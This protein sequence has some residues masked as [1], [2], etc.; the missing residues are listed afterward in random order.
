MVKS[1]ASTATACALAV[2][3]CSSTHDN[4]LPKLDRKDW[5]PAGITAAAAAAAKIERAVPGECKDP[6][7]NDFSQFPIS[8]KRFNSKVVPLGQSLCNVH[9]ETVEISVFA[10]AKERD[11]YIDDRSKGICKAATEI[12]QDAK[13][14]LVFAGLRWVAGDGNLAVQP[15]SETL[16]MK[17]RDAVGGRYI[18]S[19]C[20][21]G[22]TSDWDPPSV[23]AAFGLG[24]EIPQCTNLEL[25]P[26]ESLMRTRLLTNAQLPAALAS[27]ALQGTRV[28]I[29]TFSQR[30]K[31]VDN[32]THDQITKACGA[33]PAVGRIDCD[34]YVIIVDGTKAE[35]VAT[36][37][38]GKLAETA[39]S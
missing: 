36:A 3:G 17:I 5:T 32:F 15:D 2:A 22:V 9:D 31:Y 16:A 13:K 6:A 38:S 37:L 34:G 26:R 24:A 21:K 14:P 33:D 7:P 11:R 25:T 4:G 10:T 18:A 1:W 28:T 30:T 27:C 8:L 39:C 29:V 20:A 23:R 35:S 19:P 12:A